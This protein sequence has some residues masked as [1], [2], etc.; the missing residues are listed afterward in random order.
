MRV[1][2]QCKVFIALYVDDG[3]VAYNTKRAGDEFMQELKTRFNITT[4]PA[5]YF[6]SLEINIRKDKTITLSQKA[7]TKK[8]LEKYK[9]SNCKPAPTPMIKEADMVEEG[10]TNENF[11]YRQA[12][13]ALAYL[14][15]ATRPDISYAVGVASRSLAAPTKKDVMLV[16]RIFRYL[17]GTQHNGLTFTKKSPPQ[18][19]CYSD[20]DHGGDQDNGRSTTGIVCIFSGAAIS[21]RS[22]KQPTVAISSTEAELIAASECASEILWL[23]RLLNNLMETEKPIL[24]LDSQSA[25][26]LA[27]NPKYEYHKRTKHIKLKHFFVRECV[28]NGDFIVKHVSSELQLADMLTKP[29]YGPRLQDLSYKTGL[30]NLS[31]NS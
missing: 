30:K 23:N 19:I 13:G 24:N 4:K 16:K 8:V 29:L 10:I 21:W 5:S 2:G 22:Q 18:L 31:L 15:V 3:L 26:K 25:V 1:R 6:L 11:P 7:Y 12:V 17:K 20:A 9:M 28:N 14:S 27:H